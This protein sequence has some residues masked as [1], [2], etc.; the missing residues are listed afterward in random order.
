MIVSSRKALETQIEIDMN[1]S[2]LMELLK[3]YKVYPAPNMEVWAD[4]FLFPWVWILGGSPKTW[5][6]GGIK[7][8]IWD[9]YIC[10][11][12]NNP[13]TSKN[14]DSKRQGT[15]IIENWL[16]FEVCIF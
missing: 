10:L 7:M 4:F 1:C 11:G 15:Q 6:V 9:M 2:P 5:L 3:A 13:W 14:M 12:Y 16:I 8:V